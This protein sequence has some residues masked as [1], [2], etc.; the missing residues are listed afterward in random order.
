M[1]ILLTTK[2]LTPGLADRAFIDTDQ[3]N[4]NLKKYKNSLNLKSKLENVFQKEYFL[5]HN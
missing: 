4:L 1:P 2:L 5:S 3:C